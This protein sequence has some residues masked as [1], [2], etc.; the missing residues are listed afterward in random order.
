MQKKLFTT[1]LSSLFLVSLFAQKQ[2]QVNAALQHITVEAKEWGVLASDVA[3]LTINDQYRTAHNGVMHVYVRQRYQGIPIFGALA[4]VHLRPGGELLFSNHRFESDLAMRTNAVQPV[5]S[6]QIALQRMAGWTRGDLSTPPTI[7]QREGNRRIRFSGGSLSTHDITM[8]LE[9]FPTAAGSLRLAW[10]GMI[11]PPTGS[12]AWFIHLDA[13]DGTLLHQQNMTISCTFDHDD[14]EQCTQ[15]HTL[16]TRRNI[17]PIQTSSEQVMELA[18][19]AQYRVFPA[20]VEAPIFGNRT[21]V[22]NPADEL[23]S[24]YGWHDTDGRPGNEFTVTRGNNAHAYLDVIPDNSPDQATEPD[25]GEEL[26][27]DFPFRE[28]GDPASNEEAVLTQ[29]FYMNN[30]MH[31]FTYHYGFDE[32][33]GNFQQANYGRGGRGTDEVRAEGQDGSGLNNANFFTP[34]D[35]DRPRMQ[36]FLWASGGGNRV[37]FNSSSLT[38]NNSF[39]YGSAAFGPLLRNELTGTIVEVISTDFDPSLGCKTIFNTAQLAGNIALVSRGDCAFKQKVRNAE[40]AGAIGVIVA[41]NEDNIFTMGGV[42]TLA[43]P[44]IPAI[45]ISSTARAR[46][47]AGLNAGDLEA[48]ISI[49]NYLD[50]GFDNGVVA[51]E[52]A[53]GISNRLTGGP[54]EAFCLFNDEQMGEGWSDFFALVTTVTPNDRGELPRGIGNYVIGAGTNGPGIRRQPYSTNFTINNQTYDDIIGTRAPHPLGEVWAA[55]LWDLYWALVDRYGWDLD[56]YTGSGGNNLAIQLVIDGMKLQACRPGFID[57]RDAILAADAINNNGENEC[58][59]W[60]VFAR[61]GLGW[62]AQQGISGNRNDN[63]Q[64]F[65]VRPECI[66]TLKIEKEST[67]LIAAGDTFSVHLYVQND[68]DATVSDV[69]VT[70]QIPEGAIFIAGSIQGGREVRLEGNDLIIEVGDLLPGQRIRIDYTLQSQPD[71]QSVSIF[72]DDMESGAGGWRLRSIAGPERWRLTQT[73]QNSGEQSWYIPNVAERQDQSLQSLSPILLEGGKPVLRFFHTY[74]IE[75]GLDGGVIEVSTDGGFNWDPLPDTLLFRNE[76]TGRLAPRT[77]N[78]AGRKA[79]W[80]EDPAFTASYID[81][82]PYTGS[83]V[84]FRFRFT[85]NNGA[86]FENPPVTDGWYIDDVNLFDMVQYQSVACARSTEGDQVCTLTQRGGT[87]VEPTSLSTRTANIQPPLDWTVYPNPAGDRV[88]I[89]VAP[90]AGTYQLELSTI[91]G[92]TLQQWK[93]S[94]QNSTLNTSNLQPGLYLLQLITDQGRYTKKIIKE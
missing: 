28:N 84:N 62:N 58:L 1:I 80:G 2:N 30:F 19:G 10:S 24:P 40:D 21:L 61:R 16:S 94:E 70:D 65:D 44:K 52:Y 37:A 17:Q 59:I 51:H 43:D 82:S 23:A 92:R 56:L 74:Q 87:I 6:P 90:H 4:G 72:S 71:L 20:P 29:L 81:L 38:G 18:D 49:P 13:I 26:I 9:F 93:G 25:G 31:D 46:L 86:Q 73:R 75:P 68:K 5:V 11:V 36:M 55:T 42:D 39:P 66:K 33:A 54:A 47:Q 48:T 41:N 76:Y 15:E 35:G 27:F 85:A 88:N 91:E 83:T 78:A 22:V 89:Q 53:H 69:I 12:D 14:Q 60:E 50:S 8:Q 7:L 32:P 77:I 63:I 67:P 79:F 3:D 34:G 57:G 45:L 64:N